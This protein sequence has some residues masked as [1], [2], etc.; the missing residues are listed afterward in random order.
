MSLDAES[1]N[2]DTLARAVG[3]YVLGEASLGK[4][5]EQAEMTRWEFEAILSDAGLP[6]D[7][8]PRDEGDLEDEV[9]TALDHE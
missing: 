4:A 6:V 1:G 3:M 2:D 9:R 7:L 8:G 5:A